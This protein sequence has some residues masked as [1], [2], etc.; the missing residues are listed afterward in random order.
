MQNSH[1]YQVQLEI[2]SFPLP[3]SLSL[4]ARDFEG[5]SGS[6]RPLGEGL[7]VRGQ[8]STSGLGQGLINLLSFTL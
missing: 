5:F 7:G 6:P 1:L 2:W 8:N 4:G 3:K